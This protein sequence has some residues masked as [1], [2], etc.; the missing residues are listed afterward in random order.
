MK[1]SPS[2]SV[3]QLNNICFLSP[4]C[5][6]MPL[7]PQLVVGFLDHL[8]ASVLGFCLACAYTGLL[9][10]VTMT[11]SPSVQCSVVF[12]C[13]AYKVLGLK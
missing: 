1:N 10:A 6:Q 7:A 5:Y 9:N 13:C 8:H 3:T 2:N 11:V 12:N 4:K